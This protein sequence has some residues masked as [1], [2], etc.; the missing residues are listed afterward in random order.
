MPLRPFRH[1]RLREWALWCLIFALPL[2]GM[3]GVVAQWLGAQHVHRQ[4]AS[5]SHA[6]HHHHDHHDHAAVQR[7]HHPLTDA[8]V[9]AVGADASGGDADL[10]A[11]AGAWGATVAGGRAA[12][13]PLRGG[14]SH[15]HPG[16]TA[17]AVHGCDAWPVDKPPDGGCGASAA[18]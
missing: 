9:L 14:L 18:G 6:A 8:S 5:V 4:G 12:G 1:P 17:W 3:S 11:S 10:S 13:L 2:Q 16:S 15:E 7:H